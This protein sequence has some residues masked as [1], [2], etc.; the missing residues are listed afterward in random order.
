MKVLKLN[1]LDILILQRLTKDKKIALNMLYVDIKDYNSKFK[2][3]RTISYQY[4]WSRV[5]FLHS[6]DLISVSFTKPKEISLN[7]KKE[8][9]IVRYLAG[10]L[11]LEE[12][13]EGAKDV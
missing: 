7:K 3:F 1:E 13:C 2:K 6:L 5:D 12:V 10:V 9:I 4:L 8:K 11:G